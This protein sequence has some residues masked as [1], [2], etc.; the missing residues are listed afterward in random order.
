MQKLSLNF[1]ENVNNIATRLRVSES[2]D[3][4]E[5][6]LTVAEKSVRFFF[7]D[8]FIKDAEMLRICG[9]ITVW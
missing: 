1:Q 3:L 4:I 5:R 2:F 7:I 8:G 6:E 9:R